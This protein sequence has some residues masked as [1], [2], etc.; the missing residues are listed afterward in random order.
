LKTHALFALGPLAGIAL[1][2]SG[3]GGRDR[4]HGARAT[5]AGRRLPRRRTNRRTSRRL[6]GR[7]GVGQRLYEITIPALSIET[8]FP[9]VRQR[10]LGDFARVV[11][12]LAMSTP[13]TVLVVYHGEDEVDAWCRALSDAI[14]TRRR[15]HGHP[16]LAPISRSSSERNKQGAGVAERPQPRCRSRCGIV[17]RSPR[18]RHTLKCVVPGLGASRRGH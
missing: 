8:D 15:S 9:A 16:T 6:G 1:A 14:E 17:E 3:S 13:G 7:E 2:M 4:A 11:E 10:L 18:M 5:R 12:V